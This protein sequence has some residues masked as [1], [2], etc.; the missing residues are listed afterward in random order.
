METK[1]RNDAG[2][3]KQPVAGKPREGSLTR[4]LEREERT[5]EPHH[6][7]QLIGSE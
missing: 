6:G 4:D 1:E 7:R 3:R 2:S 5:P